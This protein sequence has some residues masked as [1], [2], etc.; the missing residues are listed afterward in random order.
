[1][2][3]PIRLS[4]LRRS[5]EAEDDTGTAFFLKVLVT[6]TTRKPR[7]S[8]GGHEVI[9]G[10]DCWQIRCSRDIGLKN[11]LQ[12]RIRVMLLY[13]H[14][15][16]GWD[17]W[18]SYLKLNTT[19]DRTCP[20]SPTQRGMLLL[21]AHCFCALCVDVWVLDTRSKAAVGKYDQLLCM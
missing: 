10:L 19:T 8:G 4:C 18:N 20:L 11:L 3:Y 7:S 6:A 21:F 17:Y 13:H 12:C 9:R 14:D 5:S 16:K 1:M 15:K 2:K